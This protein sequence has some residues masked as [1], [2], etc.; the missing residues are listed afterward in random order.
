MYKRI[1]ILRRELGLNQSEFGEKIGVSR[2]VIANIELCRVAPKDLLIKHICDIFNAREQW[3]FSGTGE[4]FEEGARP[5]KELDELW[6][7]YQTL[8][9]EF[10]EYVTSQMNQLLKLQ[11]SGS[12]DK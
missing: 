6:R 10:Q 4:M 11:T 1:R 5:N 3:L 7:L 2:A 9:P 12:G 8:K